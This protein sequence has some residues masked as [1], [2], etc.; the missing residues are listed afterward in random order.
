MEPQHGGDDG[1]RR[2]TLHQHRDILPDSD[3]RDLADNNYSA[4]GE[5]I[6]LR[7]KHDTHYHFASLVPDICPIIVSQIII[8]IIR[9]YPSSWA[10]PSGVRLLGGWGSERTSERIQEDGS[11][12]R[13]F[14]LE[15]PLK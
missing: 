9:V 6:L 8:L 7:Y 11:S 10:S 5:V 1:V 4:R 15:Y 3:R 2:R 13:G 12:V 14:T